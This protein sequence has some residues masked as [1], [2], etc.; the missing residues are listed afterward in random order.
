MTREEIL[1]L[2]IGRELD[3]LVATKVIGWKNVRT[4]QVKS[5]GCIPGPISLEDL[6]VGDEPDGTNNPVPW[7]SIAIADAWQAFLKF[8]PHIRIE[9][10]EESD[11]KQDR[12]QGEWHCDIWTNE[13][14]VCVNGATAELAICRAV[15]LVVEKQWEKYMALHDAIKE[16]IE[17]MENEAADA[18]S[19]DDRE[20]KAARSLR[21]YAKDLRRILKACEGNTQA[22]PP[23]TPLPILDPRIQDRVMIEKAREELRTSKRQTE[24]QEAGDLQTALV[25]DGPEKDTY[26]P[27]SSAMP[28]G[29]RTH[30]GKGHVYE[31]KPDGK[32]YHV[33]SKVEAAK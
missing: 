30:V 29:A 6:L 12:T 21:G 10:C 27:I 13:G 1:A 28:H 31:L 7:Y 9:C 23:M 20:V 24:L 5:Y 16:I 11:Y 26:A 25:V 8:Q 17:D 15:L 32:L 4:I 22:P 2:P 33:P 19:R 14:M 3:A 18:N